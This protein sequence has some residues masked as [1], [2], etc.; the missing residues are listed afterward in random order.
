MSALDTD[1]RHGTREL[2]SGWGRGSSSAAH[3]VPVRSQ[4]ELDRLVANARIS[5]TPIL[6]RGL[7]RSYGDAAQC[8][9]GIVLDCTTL[10]R[11]VAADFDSGVVKV[12]A[13]LSID[14]LLRH[15]ARGWFVPVT[16]G[17][18]Q[19]TVGG[20]IAADVHGKNHHRDGAFGNYVE[21]LTLVSA[22][23]RFELSPTRHPELFWAT[24][25]SM[26][27]TGA[28]AEATIRLRPIET[29]FMLVD[30][31]RS[32]DLEDCMAQLA[33]HDDRYRYSVAWVD[34]VARGRKL[35]RSVLSRGDHANLV[36]L[37]PSHLPRALEYEPR[38]L[39]GVPLT[40]PANLVRPA[41]ISAWN[42]LWYRK[43]PM[44][45][46][47]E[48]QSISSFFYPLDA[49]ARWNRL[50][51]PRGFTQYQFV[52]PFGAEPTIRKVIE[53]LQARRVAPSLAVLKRF[54]DG[55]PAPLSF[56]IEGWTL[57]LDLPLGGPGVATA[58][59]ELDELVVS[60]NG[61]VYLAKDGRLGGDRLRAMYP[62]LGEWLVARRRLDPAE[63]FVSDLWRRIGANAR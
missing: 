20:A 48:L 53:L 25:G 2:V 30:T 17:T 14:R 58:L 63:M 28:I 47:G 41:A 31:D 39:L 7:G 27:L 19:V 50:Y 4:E 11:V 9:G 51:G 24:V 15:V 13:G 62:R 12:E 57:A 43:A 21:N 49:V 8:A 29:T 35:G 22:R 37:P 10:D 6:A 3:V 54:G 61:R 23:G 26:G 36:D 32:V 5:A 38:T 60:A 33:A 40:P 46:A 18:S 45:R 44:H 52:V 1:V 55:D 56:P 59:D 34:C 16:P 42:E